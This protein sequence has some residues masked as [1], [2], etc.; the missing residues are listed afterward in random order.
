[1]VE[2]PPAGDDALR[3][4]SI[5]RNGSRPASFW[6]FRAPEPGNATP[7]LAIHG[8]GLDGRVFARVPHLAL[9]RD[10]VLVNLPNEL[11]AAPLTS[12]DDLAGEALAALDA[13]GHG[14]R[15]AVLVGS[16]FGGMVALTA[17]VLH[18]RRVAGLVLL[19][20]CAAWE[21]V[22][23][24]LRLAASLHGLIPRRAYPR[25]FSTVLLP[26]HRAFGN[27]A[28]RA[29]LRTQMLHRTK[30]FVG[31]SLAAMREFDV[32][33][34]LAAVQVPALVVH[35]R[36]DRV[37]PAGRARALAGALPRGRLLILD[38]CGH[39]PQFTHPALVSGAV[40]AFLREAGL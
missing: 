33:R 8:L 11:P 34:R 28:D 22:A 10:A 30:A 20:T 5:P 4:E 35:G 27:R 14:S 21:D 19:G 24:R 40:D 39:L 29:L 16:S 15:P 6:R 18:P 38:G 31:A 26:P 1:M 17:A 25:V 32:R 9:G 37:I 7:I 13:A 36:S 3:L 2:E 12:M 23:P